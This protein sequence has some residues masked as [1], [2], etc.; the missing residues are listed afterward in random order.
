MTSGLDI[1]Q[2]NSYYFWLI[3]LGWGF[4]MVG[5][6]GCLEGDV[7]WYFPQIAGVTGD[8]RYVVNARC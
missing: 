3:W 5:E 2:V 4:R 7:L 1:G 8:L 6:R